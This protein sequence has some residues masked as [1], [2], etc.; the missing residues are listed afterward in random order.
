M[1]T[2]FYAKRI[3]TQEE[4]NE[5]AWKVLERKFDEASDMLKVFQEE[6]HIGKRSAGWE[7]NFESHDGFFY[8]KNSIKDYLDRPGEIEIVDEYGMVY[9][10]KEF[11]K[12]VEET[13][14]G[15]HPFD[16]QGR[17]R[18]ETQYF[19]EWRSK[20]GLWIIEGEYS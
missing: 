4:V 20:D 17:S 7:F 10:F 13:F 3:P 12:E 16:S 9:T 5:I 15:R 6:F 8:D 11:W 1:S 2:N 18:N 14:G 19:H